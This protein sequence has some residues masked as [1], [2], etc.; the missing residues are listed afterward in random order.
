MH[1]CADSYTFAFTN[2]A[3]LELSP[4]KKL[5]LM[6]LDLYKSTGAVMRHNPAMLMQV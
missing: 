1:N 6:H 3:S 2:A 5:L 4:A